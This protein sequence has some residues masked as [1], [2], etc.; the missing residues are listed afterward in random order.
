MS[1]LEYMDIL[2]IND[3]HRYINVEDD[4]IPIENIRSKVYEFKNPT[5]VPNEWSPYKE[6]TQEQ[7]SEKFISNNNIMQK[8]L[9]TTTNVVVA[10]GAAAKPL[11][12]S[13]NII[14]N[15]IDIFIFGILD[16]QEFWDKVSEIARKI[17]LLTKGIHF[18]CSI[19]QK[20]KK[21]IVIIVVVSPSGSIIKEYQ[22][23]LRMYH[24]LSS[25][26]HA[27]DIPSCC[28]AYDG[29]TAYTTTLGE[30]AHSYQINIVNTKYRSITFENRLVKY[31]KRGF[32]IELIGY[33]INKADD[34]NNHNIYPNY[35]KHK[36][37][38]I[39]VYTISANKVVGKLEV[40]NIHSRIVDNEYSTIKRNAFR[41]YSDIIT[42]IQSIED[43]GLVLCDEKKSINYSLFSM[44]KV[45]NIIEIFPNSIKSI[46]EK[47]SD[48][49]QQSNIYDI[50]RMHFSK[51]IFN[52]IIQIMLLNDEITSNKK[53]NNL[54][55]E[56]I[57]LY[58]DYIPDWIITQDP[59]RQYS[60]S[61]NP[62][63]EDP[64]DWY[65]SDLYIKP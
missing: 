39:T 40:S 16:I 7:Y 47:Y 24:T 58:T 36:Y 35:L 1:Y 2:A 12:P 49:I 29:C 28:V 8:V 13:E 20:M 4:L 44:F 60:A 65:G 34:V 41:S 15:D 63:I 3:A 61:I 30:Y 64:E 18:N 26:I 42:Q 55:M 31:F 37:L 33:D 32:G 17:I 6:I 23:I 38:E 48:K 11:Y 46:V 9:N 62:I 51:T 25:I 50:K 21:G 56:Q 5:I 53:I 59:Q 54:L 57:N 19:T 10:G 27:F 14:Y 43:I 45:S 22:I 52:E